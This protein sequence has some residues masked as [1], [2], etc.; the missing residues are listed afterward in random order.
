MVSGHTLLNI[1]IAVL[2]IPAFQSAASAQRATVAGGG[3][4]DGPGGSASFSIGQAAYLTF[5]DTEHSIAQGVQQPYEISVVTGM[6][7]VDEG[8]APMLFPNPTNGDVRLQF[9][10][11][12][13]GAMYL[14]L[15]DGLGR[16]IHSVPIRSDAQDIPLHGHASGTY[17]LQ[18]TQE[19]TVIRTFR[20]VKH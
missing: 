9:H 15:S 5:S 11:A 14:R 1:V 16:T 13:Q 6:D 2:V 3:E 12:P 18:V 19:G 4:A 20:I 10:S 8:H 17:L 7:E